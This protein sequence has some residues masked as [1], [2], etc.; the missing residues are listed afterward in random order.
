MNR[1]EIYE[2]G[3]R[4]YRVRTL[5]NGNQ[6]TSSS[7]L[8]QKAASNEKSQRKEV[9]L[10]RQLH[11]FVVGHAG[12]TLQRLCEESHAKITVPSERVKSDSIQIEGL[13]DEIEKA[14]QMVKQIVQENMH[15]TPYTHFISMPITDID[16]QRKV[17]QFQDDVK[18]EFLRDVDCST[19]VD[20][21]SLHITVGMLR[22]LTPAQIAEAVEYLKSLNAQIYDILGTRSLVVN[23]G[24]VRAMEKNSANARTLYTL[25]EDF[26]G[27]ENKLQRLCT[28][29]RESFSQA[30]YID[31][32]RELKI[33][34]TVIKAR[35]ASSQKSAAA[36]GCT[37]ESRR[38]CT[39]I[40]AV[41]L[42]KKHGMLSFGTCRL[43][44]VQIAKRFNHTDS[45][46]YESEGCVL[47]P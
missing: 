40:N 30:G 34:V 45:G 18:Q 47:L 13:P 5:L 43:G 39:G 42:L 14:E 12:T 37:D 31:E 41:P 35:V 26:E 28:F 7:V 8:R 29:I 22:L 27:T 4:K 38:S 17:R 21:G 16:V 1:H 10:A 24:K 2:V 9:L 23:V 33:H 36:A 44:Q 11:R 15:K 20:P 46:A 25:A 19:F 3:G 32:K 6:N